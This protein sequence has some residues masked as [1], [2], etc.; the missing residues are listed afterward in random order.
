M[1]S[2]TQPATAYDYK[3]QQWVSGPKAEHLIREQARQT[4]AVIDD[5]GY[6]RMMG[7]SNGEAARIKIRA[8]KLAGE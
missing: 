8:Q 3:T 7:Y 5:P 2:T 4:L 6:C 1:Q